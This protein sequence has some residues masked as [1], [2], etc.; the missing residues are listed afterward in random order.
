MNQLTNSQIANINGNFIA[1]NSV[2]SAKDLPK[3][4]G[5]YVLSCADEVLYV[6]ES[7]NLRT[8]WLGH[9]YAG[10]IGLSGVS[11]HY[12]KCADHKQIEKDFIKCLRPAFNGK[13]GSYPRIKRESL[14]TG[15]SVADVK[16]ALYDEMPDD[17]KA[18]LHALK[19]ISQEMKASA[20]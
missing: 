15:K 13:H 18:A 16:Q 7:T 3:V 10:F 19:A 1:L 11:L 14:K 4:S 5:V 2:R 6:G 8:R 17:Y 12:I 20:A 9:D